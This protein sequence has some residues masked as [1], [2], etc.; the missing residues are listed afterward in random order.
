MRCTPA[1]VPP[2]PL[3]GEG[4]GEGMS[5]LLR[6]CPH[7]PAAFAAGPSLS[8]KRERERLPGN[9]GPK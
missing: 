6:T 3:A 2:L 1:N 8:R 5:R 7:P 9:T 4:R